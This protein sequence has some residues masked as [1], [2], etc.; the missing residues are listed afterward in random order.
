MPLGFNFLYTTFLLYD[1][2]ITIFLGEILVIGLESFHNNNFIN[3]PHVKLYYSIVVY[4]G[5]SV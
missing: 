2:R 4:L 1:I 3:R 5:Y